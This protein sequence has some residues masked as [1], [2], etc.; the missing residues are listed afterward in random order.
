[1][2]LATIVL[3][4]VTLQILTRTIPAFD[5]E[6]L[7][8]GKVYTV[9][10]NVKRF[11]AQLGW[12]LQ[13]GSTGTSSRTG[14][15]IEYKINSKGFRDD[16]TSYKKLEGVYRIVLIGDSRTFGFGV[17]IE[18]HFSKILEG[19]FKDVEVINMGVDG[20]GVDQELL[21]LR[22]EGCR[23]EPD[24]VLAYVAHYGNHRH[25]Y[26][27]RFGK[28]KPHFQLV[29]GNLVLKN[30]PVP[31]KAT[32]SPSIF[33]DPWRWIAKHS[34]AYG[35]LKVNLTQLGKK[36]SPS[37][38]RRDDKANA[39][40]P[41]FKDEL[42]KL[43]EAIIFEMNSESSRCGAVF[44]LVNQI[45]SLHTAAVE[46]G[47]LSINVAKALRNRKF[48]LP[49]DLKHINES[50]NGVLAWEIAQFLRMNKLIPVDHLTP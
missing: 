39:R 6:R 41:R 42:H 17:P 36:I 23:Y 4:E 27:K 1:M 30:S 46:K 12:A 38:R 19:F 14:Y 5:F 48:A 3:A 15:E 13:P 32:P 21:Q 11:D 37:K 20:Y 35:V 43:G 7:K 2:A 45:R 40:D 9:P 28:S 50:G 16:Q 10:L 26:S 25:M 33:L 34:R 47:I 24:L 29:D 49:D 8:W 22:S 44:V 31:G 18:K